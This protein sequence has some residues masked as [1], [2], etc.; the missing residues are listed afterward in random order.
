MAKIKIKG[1]NG[2]IGT[3]KIEPREIAVD[4]TYLYYVPANGNDTTAIFPVSLVQDT[5][6]NVFFKENHF[7]LNLQVKFKTRWSLKYSSRMVTKYKFW[8]FL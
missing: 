6:Q 8:I 1:V 3:R 7:K 4:N 2:L 5:Y